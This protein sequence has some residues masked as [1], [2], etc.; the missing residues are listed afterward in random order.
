MTVQQQVCDRIINMTDEG[1]YFINQVINN[2]NPVFLTG[3][4]GKE[5]GKDAVD[6]SKR[7]GIGKGII[8]DPEDF[9][10]WNDEIADLFEGAAT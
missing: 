4:S 1:A 2:M 5:S 8:E 9:D 6:V 3:N 10:K 7:I